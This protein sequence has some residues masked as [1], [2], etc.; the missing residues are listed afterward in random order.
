MFLQAVDVLTK[1][2][3]RLL[4]GLACLPLLSA[5]VLAE[6]QAEQAEGQ[7]DFSHCLAGLQQQARAEGLPAYVVNEVMAGLQAQE[8]VLQLDRRQPEFTQTFADYLYR[9]LTSQRIQR[10]RELRVQYRE[11]LDRL[12]RSYGVPGH[13]L[14]AFW[15]LETNFGSY[16]GKMP[17][18]DSLATLA[19]DERRSRFFTLE[20]LTALKLLHRESLSAETMR[21]SWAGAMGHTQF[22]P[23]AYSRYAVDG[24]SDSRVDLWNSERDALA[25]GANFLQNLGWQRGERW[26]REVLLPEGFAYAQTGLANKRHMRY[27][28]GQGVRLSNGAPLPQVDIEG[29]ILV[30]AGHAGPAF[31]VYQNFHVIMRW[32]RSESY[33]LSVGLLADRIAGAGDLVRPPSSEEPALSR[34]A[35][36]SMQTR[37]NHLGF[38]AGEADGVLGP[39]TRT[40]LRA[41]QDSAGFIADGYPDS[42]TL[43]ALDV[44]PEPSS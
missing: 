8:R 37:L 34:H 2:L 36:E 24:D 1:G 5:T 39:A 41:F 10:G 38:D 21:G 4:A 23:S 40:A 3:R 9:R 12:T 18:L 35:I 11:F 25:S 31:L 6:Q 44:N 15:G 30:P 17:I 33:A 43:G 14:L 22:M 7:Q 13:Y 28:A 16:L 27:W 42:K 26:G 32:N 29:S 19:C 20:L